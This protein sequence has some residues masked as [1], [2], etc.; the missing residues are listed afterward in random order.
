MIRMKRSFWRWAHLLSLSF[1]ALPGCG[2]NCYGDDCGCEGESECIISC[3]VAGCDLS[4]SH[5]ADSCGAI[6]GDDCTFDCHDT[7]HCSSLSEDDSQITC[8]NVPSCA[9]ECGADCDYEAHNVSTVDVTVGP[10]STVSC[11]QMSRCE[12]TCEGPCE[13]QCN[14]VDTCE[15]HCENGTSEQGSGENRSCQ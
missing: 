8:H 1:F 10:G 6:C 2:A 15:L 13:V 12:V 3:P 9:A 5:A 7:D 14:Q 4:C 11:L